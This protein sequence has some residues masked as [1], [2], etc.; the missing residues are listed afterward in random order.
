M[1]K[2]QIDYLI[3]K[4]LIDLDMGFKSVLMTRLKNI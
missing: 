4:I 3:K 1:D 2:K